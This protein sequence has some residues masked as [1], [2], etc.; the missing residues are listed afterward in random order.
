MST[1]L[2]SFHRDGESPGAGWIFVFGSNLAGRHGAGSAKAAR[3]RYGARYGVGVG[4]TGSAYA[5]P[6]KDGRSGGSLSRPAEI[7][8]LA[9]VRGHIEQFISYARS[10][11]EARFFVTRVG[12]G[13]AG[14]K[15]DEI[16]PAFAGA[17]ANCSLPAEWKRY[18][19]AA[20]A[21]A[22]A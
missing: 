5:I 1:P 8:P 12:C 9:V 13:L 3:E 14:F 4:R 21:V 11:P 17:P 7:L 2:P 20:R 19:D 16:G 10:N 18:V 22:T 15:D 6:T